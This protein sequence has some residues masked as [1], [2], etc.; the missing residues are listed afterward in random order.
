MRLETGDWSNFR[1]I[2]G[3]RESEVFFPTGGACACMH[4]AFAEKQ[5]RC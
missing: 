1:K 4:F 3:T 2:L 5:S